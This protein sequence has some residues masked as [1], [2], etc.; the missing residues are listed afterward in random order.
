MLHIMHPPRMIRTNMINRRKPKT[1][2][3]SQEEPPKNNPIIQ[4][5]TRIMDF[6]VRVQ[7]KWQNQHPHHRQKMAID[8]TRLVV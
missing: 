3:P 7:E 2:P 1:N 4:P 5:S 8:I 6:R